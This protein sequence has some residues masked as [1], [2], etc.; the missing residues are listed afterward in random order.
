[1]CLKRQLEVAYDFYITE[2]NLMAASFDYR[3]AILSTL[4]GESILNKRAAELRE[5]VGGVGQAS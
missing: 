5:G 3:C 1:M 2:W 4:R